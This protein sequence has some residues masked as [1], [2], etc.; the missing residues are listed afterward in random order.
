MRLAPLIALSIAA[1]AIGAC[2]T[3]TG[4][5]PVLATNSESAPQPVEGYDWHFNLDSDEAQ[6]AYGLAQSDDLKLGLDCRKGS[7]RLTLTAA[8]DVAAPPE[9]HLESGG[10]TER[11]AAMKE[12][13][14]V[15]DGA[16]LT[17]E[18]RTSEPVFLRFRHVGWLAAW[19]G[20][21]REAYVPHPASASQIEQFFAFC[22]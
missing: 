22:G 6:L 8:V 20:D 16:L 19:K 1:L 15:N 17:A 13:A 14:E 10:D 12:P 11:F 9:F 3:T 4:D 18:A 21:A 5:T 2:T 7:G